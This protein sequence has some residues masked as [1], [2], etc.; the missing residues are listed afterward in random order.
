MSK[1]NEKKSAKRGAAVITKWVGVST[2]IDYD[3]ESYLKSKFDAEYLFA[4]TIHCG[5]QMF[6]ATE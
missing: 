6:C 4:E 1:S 5:W 2:S 3:T